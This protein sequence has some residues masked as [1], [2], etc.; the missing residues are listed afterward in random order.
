MIAAWENQK[1]RRYVECVLEAFRVAEWI[2]VDESGGLEPMSDSV[3]TE[4]LEYGKKVIIA[5]NYTLEDMCGCWSDS[6]YH[7]AEPDKVRKTIYKFEDG[8]LTRDDG[9]VFE[10]AWLTQSKNSQTSFFYEFTD[11][12]NPSKCVA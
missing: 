10:K 1:A 2:A 4:V 11:I 12:I 9:P 7:V 6:M 8:V 5:V 3:C